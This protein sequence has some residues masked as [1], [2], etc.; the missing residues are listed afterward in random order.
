MCEIP[1]LH[2]E[3]MF[4]GF[5]ALRDDQPGRGLLHPRSRHLR[6][7]GSGA[8]ERCQDEY[9]TNTEEHYPEH[10]DHDQERAT[11]QPHE[12]DFLHC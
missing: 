9:I 1:I 6:E 7:A 5:L 3:A 12:L 4:G 2:V 8:R 11:V 10:L